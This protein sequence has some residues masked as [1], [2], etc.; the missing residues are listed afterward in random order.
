MEVAFRCA[1]SGYGKRLWAAL[2]IGAVFLTAAPS[3]AKADMPA[4]PQQPAGR[5]HATPEPAADKGP[6]GTQG[7]IQVPCTC[8]YQGYDYQQGETVCIKGRLARCGMVLN[9]TSWAITEESCPAISQATPPPSPMPLRTR[10]LAAI[11]PIRH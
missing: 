1:R 5:L 10:Q 7:R 3:I 9:N 8:R 6:I 4:A 2:L 11:T